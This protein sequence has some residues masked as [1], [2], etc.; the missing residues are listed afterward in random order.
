LYLSMKNITKIIIVGIKILI[1]ILIII[2]I[3]FLV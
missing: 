3:L 1:T 2:K